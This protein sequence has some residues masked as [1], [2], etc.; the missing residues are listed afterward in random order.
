MSS[1]S[2]IRDSILSDLDEK[3]KT[4]KESRVCLFN[5]FR[6][7]NQSLKE[8]ELKH[9][10]MINDD[11][12][13]LKLPTEVTCMI[14]DLSYASHFQLEPKSEKRPLPPEVVVSHVCKQWRE[15]S[16][17]YPRLWTRFFFRAV[18]VDEMTNAY[19]RF[20][21]Y[22]R[23][24]CS[25]NLELFFDFNRPALM[26]YWEWELEE[27]VL[28]DMAVKQIKHWKIVMFLSGWSTEIEQKLEPELF[29]GYAPNL[30]YFAY[31]PT[32]MNV[33]YVN[34][35]ST[36]TQRSM[37]TSRNPTNFQGGA[38]KLRYVLLDLL[39][40]SILPLSNLTTLC[41]EPKN[42]EAEYFYSWIVFLQI[43][44]IPSLTNLSLAGDIFARP[45]AMNLPRYRHEK[46]QASLFSGF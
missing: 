27:L 36:T 42:T 28:I 46:P 20:D 13:L 15:A 22:I 39:S 5:K 30:E 24:S 37:I 17:G 9:A 33:N 40:P 34:D 35:D 19:N 31:A 7:M 10:K 23:R 43:L 26:I 8:I 6:H 3:Q 21:M 12:P 14:F 18:D 11:S 2:P 16:L 1:N 29:M 32:C 44:S 41:I 25:Q 45:T 38:S 4:M